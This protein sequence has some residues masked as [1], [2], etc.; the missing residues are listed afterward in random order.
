MLQFVYAVIGFGVCYIT[1]SAIPAPFSYIIA[2]PVAFF[3]VLI[4]FVK[5]NERPFLDFFKSAIMFAS[6]PRQRFWHQGDD[7]DLNI[8]IYEVKKSTGPA[9]ASKGIS[10]AEI[11]NFARSLDSG[12]DGKLL[13]R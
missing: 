10:T 5:I 13:K 4:D 2:A 9:V 6:S 1:I 8:E 7:T 12:G 11:S 3:V